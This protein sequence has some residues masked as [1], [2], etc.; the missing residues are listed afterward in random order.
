MSLLKFMI[1]AMVIM[2]LCLAWIAIS[3][4]SIDEQAVIMIESSGRPDA[5]SFLGE[6]Y[7]KG[8]YQISELARRDYN[9]YHHSAPILSCELLKPSK[10]RLIYLWLVEERIP[11]LLGHYGIE[12]TDEA[13]L[14]AYNLGAFAY[15]QGK[16]N[17]K[18]IEKYERAKGGLL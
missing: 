16:R 1:T 2:L 4:A 7:G 9:Q 5:V 14:Q 12:V 10:G 17:G 15:A 3:E 8:L 13:V 18:Y 6:Q 11:Q